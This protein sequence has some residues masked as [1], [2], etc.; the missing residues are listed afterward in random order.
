MADMH[1]SH[2]AKYLN[3]TLIQHESKGL[4]SRTVSLTK[5]MSTQVITY[6]NF[7]MSNV[8]EF[9]VQFHAMRIVTTDSCFKKGLVCS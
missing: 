9:E 1:D 2:E 4:A 5:K 7:W 6:P 8:L 3:T